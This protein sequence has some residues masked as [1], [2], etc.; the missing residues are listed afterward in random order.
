MREGGIPVADVELADP[1]IVAGT[2]E[3][4]NVQN[5]V[6]LGGIAEGGGRKAEEG[7]APRVCVA[8][9]FG[10]GPRKGEELSH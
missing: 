10:R 3:A 6:T 7:S 1:V 9:W 5:E 4:S 8:D 2:G